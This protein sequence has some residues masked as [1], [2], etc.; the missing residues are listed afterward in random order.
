M[1][2]N[3]HTFTVILAGVLAG[4]AINAIGQKKYPAS[5][6]WG[7]LF[8][9]GLG[10]AAYVR[11]MQ[12]SEYRFEDFVSNLIT[13]SIIFLPIVFTMLYRIDYVRTLIKQLVTPRY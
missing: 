2:S 3:L 5:V 4:T 9:A 13:G 12:L 10:A 8:F 11:T 6:V 7:I 1:F